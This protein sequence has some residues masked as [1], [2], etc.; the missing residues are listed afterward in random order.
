MQEKEKKTTTPKTA[1]P[2]TKTVESKTAEPKMTDKT[3]TPKTVTP[4]TVAPKT[5]MP[6]TTSPKT[7]TPKTTDKTVEPKT[8]TPKT[9]VPKTTSPKTT[10]AKTI[11]PKTITPKTTE[12]NPEAVAT[13]DQVLGQKAQKSEQRIITKDAEYD[14][15]GVAKIDPSVIDNSVFDDDVTDEPVSTYH[16]RSMTIDHTMLSREAATGR[17]KSGRRRKQRT[18]DLTTAERYDPDPDVGLSSEVVQ[19]RSQQGY[20]NFVKKKSGK[21]Y[22]SI[23]VSNIFTFFNMLTFIVAAALLVVGAGATQLFFIVIIA[24]N[25]VIGI[26]QEIR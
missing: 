9:V 3:V 21:S 16:Y 17:R 2:K 12:R 24:A 23:F 18:V 8:V 1:S 20:D 26:F 11:T 7:I 10:T 19:T 6:K 5:V 22:L 14:R 25:V 13:A 4:K 15:G